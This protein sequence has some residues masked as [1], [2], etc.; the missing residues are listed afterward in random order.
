MS[1]FF[2]L[3]CIGL[4]LTGHPSKIGSSNLTQRFRAPIAISSSGF[5]PIRR[6]YFSVNSTMPVQFSGCPFALIAAILFK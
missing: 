4:D 1:R 6:S 3:F 2:Y 5:K